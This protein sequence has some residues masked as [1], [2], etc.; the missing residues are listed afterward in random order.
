MDIN[1]NEQ[2]AGPQKPCTPPATKT[3]KADAQAG[4]LDKECAKQP[5][6]R[7]VRLIGDVWILLIVINLLSGTKRF[8]ELLEAMGRVSSKTLSQ[9]LKLLETL[10]IVE[11]QAFYE[12]P[13]RVE[14]HLTEKGRDLGRII[15]EI[16]QFAQKHLA[17]EDGKTVEDGECNAA[18]A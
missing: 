1:P 11:R 12:I 5:M 16:E 13:P 4:G 10:E 7:A 15:E 9:R 3:A 14:Y 6:A 17:K 8:N 18:D 2:I